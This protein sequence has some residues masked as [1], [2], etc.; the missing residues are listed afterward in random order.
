[1]RFAKQNIR[2]KQSFA[3]LVYF[4]HF[5]CGEIQSS[6]PVCELGH[7]LSKGGF[8]LR[9]ESGP[10]KLCHRLNQ[11]F[12]Q[13]FKAVLPGKP[14]KE[15][16]PGPDLLRRAGP[17]DG[18]EPQ[19][20]QNQQDLGQLLRVLG[21]DGAVS[22]ALPQD[23]ED[24]MGGGLPQDALHLQGHK[25]GVLNEEGQHVQ[26]FPLEGQGHGGAEHLP[27][28]L[29]PGK[30]LSVPDL[31]Q[32]GAV[33]LPHPVHHGDED[34]LLGDEMVVDGSLGQLGGVDDVL[35]GGFV[36]ALLEK[37]GGCGVQNAL[38]GLLR[39][40]VPGHR[41]PSSLNTDRWSVSILA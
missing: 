36:V 9:G 12:V 6:A 13:Q 14:V 16:A 39:V 21:L 2:S 3:N 37:E 23:G 18:V 26:D 19:V 33:K 41:G 8:A 10:G 4:I 20:G 5:A 38:Y 40:L 31:G 1:M 15:V 24:V 30:A 25:L 28:L 11:V 34:G 35:K 22:D 27:Q 7:L 29:R 17:E 32:D